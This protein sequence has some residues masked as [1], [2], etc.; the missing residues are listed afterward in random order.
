MTHKIKLNISGESFDVLFD[1]DKEIVTSP[2]FPDQP[3]TYTASCGTRISQ[4][5]LL[6]T[7]KKKLGFI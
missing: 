5:M 2:D 1:E 4:L 3:I 6:L 7:C